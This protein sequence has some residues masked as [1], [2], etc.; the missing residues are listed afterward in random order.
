VRIRVTGK[1]RVPGSRFK[2]AVHRKQFPCDGQLRLFRPTALVTVAWGKFVRVSRARAPPQ[3]GIQPR[4]GRAIEVTSIRFTEA[5]GDTVKLSLSHQLM[6]TR[7]GTLPD[8]DVSAGE[9]WLAM[10]GHFEPGTLNFADSTVFYVR[11]FAV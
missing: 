1:V 9:R 2:V 10:N 7:I 3:V 6:V 5:G 11:F 8:P 4:D